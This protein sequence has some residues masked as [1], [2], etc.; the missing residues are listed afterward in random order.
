MNVDKLMLFNFQIK[1]QPVLWRL[2]LIG[3]GVGSD[4]ATEAVATA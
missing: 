1:F 2:W 4:S 3:N